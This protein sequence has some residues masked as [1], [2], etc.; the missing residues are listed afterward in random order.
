[1]RRNPGAPPS[2][3][4][5][6]KIREVAVTDV[7]ATVTV[8]ATRTAVPCFAFAPSFVRNPRASVLRLRLELEVSNAIAE[9]NHPAS[10]AAAPVPQS[11]RPVLST[12]HRSNASAATW[13]PTALYAAAADVTCNVGE[14]GA[15]CVF[16]NA[17]SGALLAAEIV[18]GPVRVPPDSSNGGNADWIAAIA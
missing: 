16:V 7:S 13:T 2:T 6:R 18:N 4:L 8:P 1:M 17:R 10:T 9:R 3:W 15:A 11:S 5:V 12:C 14:V